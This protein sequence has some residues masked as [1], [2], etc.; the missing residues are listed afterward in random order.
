[1]HVYLTDLGTVKYEVDYNSIPMTDLDGYEVIAKFQVADFYNNQTFYTD[2]NG[3]EMQERKLNYRPTW[4]FVNT[5][6]ADSN[7]N[8]TGNYFPVQSALSML[9]TKS[10]MIFTVMNDRSQGASALEEGT[11]AF[12]QNRR[13]PGN[14]CKGMPESLSEVDSLGNGIRVRATY[15]IQLFDNSK[16]KNM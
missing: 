13:T 15:D 14:D 11:I 9:D 10:D 6:L 16:T 1:M 5:N 7:E 12:M 3:M 8:I 4:D 2:S